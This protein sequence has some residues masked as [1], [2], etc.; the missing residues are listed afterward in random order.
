MRAGELRRFVTLKSV[1]SVE[2]DY[3][4]STEVATEVARVRA[5]VEALPSAE[6]L[7]AMQSK[8]TSP[9]RFTIRY[10]SD[11]SGLTELIYEGRKYNVTSVTD[12]DAKR[13]DLE[14]LADEAAT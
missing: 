1:V 7:R 12:P 10:R 14:I 11:V 8:M 5:K 13:R 3:G 6:P 4:G 2:D 9:H